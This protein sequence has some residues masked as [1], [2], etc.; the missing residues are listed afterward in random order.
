M[1]ASRSRWFVGSSSS[2]TSGSA[3]SARASSTRRRHPPESVST[4]ASDGSSRRDNTSSTRCSMR[5]PS[6]RSRSCCRRPSFSSRAG[7]LVL[8]HLDGGV[9]IA[10][11]QVAQVAQRVGDDVED[12]AIGGDRNILVESGKAQPRL[13]PHGPGVGGLLAADDAQQRRLSGAVPSEDR[14]PL[15]PV[16][17]E[18]GVAEQREVAECDRDL[19]ERDERHLRL[20]GRMVGQQVPGSGQH[21]RPVCRREHLQELVDVLLRRSG[22]QQFRDARDQFLKSAGR[23]HSQRLPFTPIK[24]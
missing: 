12:R 20:P 1:T 7:V 17:P 21:V 9:V 3:A 23:R 24:D 4:R 6:A 2:S 11:D 18:R 16:N 5:Q 19:V 10:R 8:G 15:P 22:F 13:A 14:D